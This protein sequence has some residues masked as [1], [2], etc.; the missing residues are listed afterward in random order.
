MHG[1]GLIRII[2]STTKYQPVFTMISPS[3]IK[4]QHVRD[5]PMTNCSPFLTNSVVIPLYHR[6]HWSLKLSFHMFPC[7]PHD[8]IESICYPLG[9]DP[10]Y[11]VVGA[12]KS[13]NYF[14][15]PIK[16]SE[17][18]IVPLKPFITLYSDCYT[19][20]LALNPSWVLLTH[21]RHGLN[22]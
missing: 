13:N 8:I 20:R 4:Y 17:S 16:A 14:R 9:C 22:S 11:L 10:P 12:G 2:S 3:L 1:Y 7:Y 15:E 6:H 19:F 18:F 5:P 21:E